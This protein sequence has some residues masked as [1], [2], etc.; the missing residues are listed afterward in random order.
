[1]S[2]LAR[3]NHNSELS[4]Q[5]QSSSS[6]GPAS[7]PTLKARDESSVSI[8]SG[9]HHSSNKKASKEVTDTDAFID[10]FCSAGGRAYKVCPV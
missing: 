8:N 1:M 2:V 10:V 9:T 3:S 4:E 5:A 6:D 7:P